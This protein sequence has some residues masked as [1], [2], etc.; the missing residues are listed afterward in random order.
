LFYPQR[1]VDGWN[2]VPTD[3]KNSDWEKLQN[4]LQKTQGRIG[5]RH[6]EGQDW[7]KDEVDELLESTI[8]FARS[9][10]DQ[11]VSTYKFLSKYISNSY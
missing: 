10:W 6:I 5:A 8:V 7:R 4:G 3:I 9:Q 1:E 11:R 2:K